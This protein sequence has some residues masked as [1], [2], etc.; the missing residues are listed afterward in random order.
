MPKTDKQTLATG[1]INLDDPLLPAVIGDYQIMK[2]DPAE[3]GSIIQEIFGA[4]GPNRFDLDQIKVPSGQG[5]AMWAVPTLEGEDD[6]VKTIDGVVIA[7]QDIRVYYRKSFDAG[8]GGVPPDCSS[9]DGVRGHGDPG[10]DC[11]ECTFALW[12][13]ALAKANGEPRKGQACQ[14]KRLLWMVRPEQMLPSIVV[15]PATSLKPVRRYQLALAGRGLRSW[16]V[17]TSLALEKAQ[18]GDGIA[19]YR[20]APKMLG[21]LSKAEIARIKPLVEMAAPIVDVSDYGSS[22]G[23]EPF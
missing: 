12:G 20:I 23:D 15:V 16:Q 11:A 13:S 10:G 21:K 5:P 7:T 19:Y 17:A 22:E 6:A 2:H 18:S 8:G 1:L 3:V 4:S 14:A 9:T